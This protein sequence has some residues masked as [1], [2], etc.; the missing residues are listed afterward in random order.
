MP[1]EEA[2]RILRKVAFEIR[3]RRLEVPAILLF[4]SH[5]PLSYLGGQA[6]FFFAPFLVPIL[7]YQNV[8]DYARILN[9]RDSIDRL[10]QYLEGPMEALQA[11][12]PPDVSV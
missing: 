5:K 12:D 9:R 1:A 4:E 6:T 7:G 10:L 3:R 2:D 8:Q 11:P